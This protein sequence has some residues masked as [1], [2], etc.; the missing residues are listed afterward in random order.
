METSIWRKEPHMPS[1]SKS[2]K[3]IASFAKALQF[4][5]HYHAT[6]INVLIW[7]SQ[8][9]SWTAKKHTINKDQIIA[10]SNFGV[11]RFSLLRGFVFCFQWRRFLDPNCKLQKHFIQIERTFQHVPH[12]HNNVIW[13]DVWVECSANKV[14]IKSK[15]GP[16][17][18][19]ISGMPQDFVCANV[20]LFCY[21]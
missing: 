10:G 3:N 1:P 17:N 9:E 13:S 19:W 6:F 5:C 21:W 7:V 4:Q 2:Q 18:H 20:V 15:V 16:G 12:V 11:A 14:K 8:F